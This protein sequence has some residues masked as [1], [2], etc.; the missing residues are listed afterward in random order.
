MNIRKN[1][2]YTEMY[3]DLDELMTRQLP[4][5]ELYAGS[6]RPCAGEPKRVLL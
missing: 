4:Q 5:M 6:A 2:D 1:I 3:E